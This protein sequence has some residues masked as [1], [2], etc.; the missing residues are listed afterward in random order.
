[1]DKFNKNLDNIRAMVGELPSDYEFEMECITSEIKK[2]KNNNDEWGLTSW[3]AKYIN[4]LPF[5]KKWK[6]NHIYLLVHELFVSDNT[7]FDLESIL[8][9]VESGIIGECSVDSIIKYPNEPENIDDLSLYVR[10]FY[11]LD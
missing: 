1:M 6:R 9:N 4:N 2:Y 3:M 10:G 8:Y 7:I 5:Q 11:W